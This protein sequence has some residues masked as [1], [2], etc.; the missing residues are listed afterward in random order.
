MTLQFKNRSSLFCVRHLESQK[1]YSTPRE[2]FFVL[3]SNWGEIVSEA[4]KSIFIFYDIGLQIWPQNTFLEPVLHNFCFRKGQERKRG[5]E[6]ELGQKC[7]RTKRTW[8]IQ[9]KVTGL[10]I[11]KIFQNDLFRVTRVPTNSAFSKLS[12]LKPENCAATKSFKL[13]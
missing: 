7:R 10:K 4:Q 3:H 12:S 11:K 5:K 2:C 13:L 6:T 9:F 8:R 1:F